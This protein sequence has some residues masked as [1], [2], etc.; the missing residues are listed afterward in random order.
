MPGDSLP[1]RRPALP[2]P[3]R[4]ALP[5]REHAAVLLQEARRHQLA[6]IA[7]FAGIALFTLLA[8]LFLVPQK[9]E[10]STTIIAQDSGIIQ[11]LLEGRAVATGVTDRAGIAR[12]VI[13][14]RRVMDAV[15][16]AGGWMDGN[17]SPVQKDRLI[18]QIRERIQIAGP[19]EN[20][21]QITYHDSDPGRAF[22]VTNLLGDLLIKETL[23]TKE[24][25]SR[26]A[27][28]FIESRVEDYHKK[29]IDAERN[30]QAYRSANADA[31]PGSA[32]DSTT[33]IGALRSHVEDARM[34]L[35]EQQSRAAALAGQVSG[36]SAVTAVQTRDSL[37][38][39][40]L[41]DLQAQL[42][43]LLLSYTEQY[44]D[45]VRIRHQ[46]ADIQAA[47]RAESQRASTQDRRPGSAPFESAQ[48]N[49]MYNELR[50]RL[51]E[52]RHELAGTRSRMAAAE[53][54]LGQELGRSRRIAASESALAELTRDYEVN[55]D[56][57]QDLLRRRENARVSME[58]D[59]EQRGLTMRVQDP[60]VMPVRPSGLRFLHIAIAGLAVAIAVPIAL[61]FALVR[62]DP[63]VRSTHQIERSTPYPILAVVPPYRTTRENRLQGAR[64][65]ASATIL[66]LVMLG[67]VLAYAY[68]QMHA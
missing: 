58:L 62:L 39:G 66:T 49:P 3:H 65:A 33:R 43:T 30:L 47:M 40:Q 67:Y 42:D 11:P 31:Q 7:T 12:Q 5:P 27:Y 6:L 1:A 14:G 37:Y 38:R 60:A 57:Y 8:G 44:P 23:A 16:R 51:A 21:V 19:R 63:R 20:L 32:T 25:E 61:L 18:E 28:E 52:T 56:I 22:R 10:A 34:E 36:E 4:A 13:F 59:R 54:L 46:I 26:D 17:L 15:V 2:A 64:T 24:R 53:A 50:S 41:I 35:M 68:K 48:L 29:L 45:V 9:Y 55:R